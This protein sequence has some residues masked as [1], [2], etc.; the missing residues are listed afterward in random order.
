M[1]PFNKYRKLI[2]SDFRANLKEPSF[3]TLDPTIGQ[4]GHHY[5]QQGLDIPAVSFNQMID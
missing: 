3:M 5:S 4:R 1:H 2:I